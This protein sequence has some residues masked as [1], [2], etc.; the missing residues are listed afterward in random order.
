MPLEQRLGLLQTF[1]IVRTSVRSLTTRAEASRLGEEDAARQPE[2]VQAKRVLQLRRTT[3]FCKQLVECLKE[4]SDASAYQQ[5]QQEELVVLRADTTVEPDLGQRSQQN[6]SR[7]DRS[8]RKDF[9][10]D[11]HTAATS[12]NETVIVSVPSFDSE[13]EPRRRTGGRIARRSGCTRCSAWSAAVCRP[14]PTRSAP[15]T[16][17]PSS[18]NDRSVLDGLAGAAVFAL[19]EEHRVV[20]VLR[21]LL[22]IVRA[23][24]AWVARAHVHVQRDACGEEHRHRP[25]VVLG[26][27]RVGDVRVRVAHEQ[28]VRA[29]HRTEVDELRP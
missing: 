9:T 7:G 6:T 15:Q 25:L 19:R 28:V 10:H 11:K 12:H 17:D 27:V 3:S 26:H 20:W 13:T 16:H 14:A 8:D 24:D 23:D 2:A 18:V 21:E 29:Q 4:S 1:F 22:Y 5:K